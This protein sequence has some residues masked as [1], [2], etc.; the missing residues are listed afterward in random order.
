[1]TARFALA[2]VLSSIALPAAADGDTSPAGL[3]NGSQVDVGAELEL[4]PDGRFSYFLAYGAL[5]EMASGTWSAEDGSIVLTSDTVI[6]PA[7]VL[8]GSGAGRGGS[9]AIELATP[10]AIPAQY[11]A[12]R[13][14]L[15]DGAEVFV[16]FD[17]PRTSVPVDK[18]NPPATIE[19]A[20]PIF[21]AISPPFEL[22]ADV[23]RLRF[24]FEPNDLGRVAFDR[25]V[26]PPQDGGYVLE[27]HGRRLV[28]RKAFG[29]ESYSSGDLSIE[30]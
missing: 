10:E 7:F 17:G 13:L 27:R 14:V 5:D 6:A 1:M 4:Q 26:L 23:R 28:F 19:L 21:E 3:Y 16:D 12:A 24:R 30:E 11:F 18:S 20:F 8:E 22:A 2:L 9:L 25:Q 15:A 29:A